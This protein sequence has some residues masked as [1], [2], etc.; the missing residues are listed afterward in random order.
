M[1][2]RTVQRTCCDLWHFGLFVGEYTS[3]IREKKEKRRKQERGKEEREKVGNTPVLIRNN[4]EKKK[5][6]LRYRIRKQ[7]Q[8]HTQFKKSANY[9]E[10]NFVIKR[11]S[12]MAASP[13]SQANQTKQ[14]VFVFRSV[15]SSRH[16]NTSCC[17][18]L[19]TH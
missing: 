1:C 15:R 8:T 12:F 5:T 2:F 10:G 16:Q 13:P 19:R 7:N 4:T 17:Q 3:W 18:C 6:S 14:I 9:Y 11:W